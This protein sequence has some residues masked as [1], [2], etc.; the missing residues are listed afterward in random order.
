[1]IVDLYWA[2]SEAAISETKQKYGKYCHTI[3]YNILASNLDAEEC[4]N[5]TYARAWDAMPPHRPEKLSAFLGK[6]TRNIALNRYA[7]EGAQKRASGTTLVL[8]EV[9]EFVPAAHGSSIADEIALKDAI[10]SFLASLP[11]KARMI[12]VRRYW[13]LSPIAEIARDFGM[14]E[15]NVK[16]TLMRTRGKFKAHLEN[17][18]IEI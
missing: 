6:L 18:G 3:A 15:S 8:D 10:N 9:A 11:T 5:D 2:R 16:V 14:S 13:Y 12:F 4:V 7:R 17:E 1:M